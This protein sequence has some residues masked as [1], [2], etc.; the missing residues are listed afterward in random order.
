MPTQPVAV[1]RPP[2]GS[3]SKATH[4]LYWGSVLD[5]STNRGEAAARPCASILHVSC[6]KCSRSSELL[7]SWSKSSEKVSWNETLA[8]PGET[9]GLLVGR[10]MGGGGGGAGGAGGGGSSF[11]EYCT[12]RCLPNLVVRQE[13]LP[14]TKTSGMD[15]PA[16]PGGQPTICVERT[17]GKMMLHKELSISHCAVYTSMARC[18]L[19]RGTS[20]GHSNDQRNA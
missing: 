1:W 11:L 13:M 15:R 3:K 18:M 17:K 19:A 16:V 9:G 6:L 8:G 5:G 7:F 20:T 10:A 2:H 4:Q 14:L 12:T